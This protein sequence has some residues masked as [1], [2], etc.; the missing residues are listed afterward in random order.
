[1]PATLFC[2]TFNCFGGAW[3]QTCVSTI[4]ALRILSGSSFFASNS[5]SEC[6]FVVTTALNLP[7]SFMSTVLSELGWATLPDRA[8]DSSLTKLS[9]CSMPT[10]GG[11]V[12]T[13]SLLAPFPSISSSLRF[14]FPFCCP[15]PFNEGGVRERH[16]VLFP[17]CCPSS[18]PALCGWVVCVTADEVHCVR[19]DRYT[20][21]DWSFGESKGDWSCGEP[22]AR[23]WSCG[24][25]APLSLLE[26]SSGEARF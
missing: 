9:N 6:K 21:R 11:L 4:P 8:L 2:C 26:P 12:I 16:C 19:L 5:V 18:S 3:P 14:P 10:W 1:M 17:F 23:D 24:E 20:A 7:T 15:L 22:P 13:F 25:P